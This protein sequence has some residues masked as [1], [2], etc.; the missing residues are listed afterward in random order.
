MQPTVTV[1]FNQLPICNL[2]REPQPAHAGSCMLHSSLSLVLPAWILAVIIGLYGRFKISQLGPSVPGSISYAVTFLMYAVMIT[3]GFIVHSL[4]LV[5]C[6]A[7]QVTQVK[8]IFFILLARLQ[9]YS[10]HTDVCLRG[11]H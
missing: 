5:E 6:G 1:L 2:S 11:L 4:F 3:S 9:I 7:G 10:L 8:S